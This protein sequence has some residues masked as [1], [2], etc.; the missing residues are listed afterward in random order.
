MRTLIEN[1]RQA[2]SLVTLNQLTETHESLRERLGLEAE[3][4]RLRHERSLARLENQLLNEMSQRDNMPGAVDAL[5]RHLVPQPSLSFAAIVDVSQTSPKMVALRG[6]HSSLNE[7][8]SIPSQILARLR[9]VPWIK[10]SE[11]PVGSKFSGSRG[12]TKPERANDIW[13]IGIK[14]GSAL[15]AV[16]VTNSLWPAAVPSDEQLDLLNRVGQTLARLIVRDHTIRQHDDELRTSREMLALRAITD[17][18]ADRP[19]ETLDL[20]AARLREA[21]T[22]DRASVFLMSRRLDDAYEPVASSSKPMHKSI[23]RVWKRHESKLAWLAMTHKRSNLLDL[24]RLRTLGIDSLIGSAASWPLIHEGR[25]L[26][27]IVS[28]RSANDSTAESQHRLLDWSADLLAGTLCRIFKDAAIR[29]QARHDG[30]TDLTNRR[31]FDTLLAGEVDRVRLGLTSECSLLLADL[32]R[33]KSINDTHG[34]PAGDEVLRVV[35]Q[36]LR[37][38]VGRMRIGERSVLAR[39]GGEE[40]AVLLPGVGLAGALRLG[41]EIRTA[42]EQRVIPF[43]NKS[44][45]VTISIGAASCPRHAMAPADIISAADNALYRAKSNGRNRVCLPDDA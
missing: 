1:T 33:F 10:A 32:D 29:R 36:L 45:G 26:G 25:L 17:R 35:A 14:T 19:L 37:E 21:V 44:L 7:S 34:H 5:L 42:I 11:E 6:S 9:V 24:S 31:T 13:L 40:L 28:T 3:V 23:E 41:E 43:Q 18:A 16:L 4:R 8:L 22:M 15:V 39:Y 38:H 20:F 30:L 12:A 27:S 2:G